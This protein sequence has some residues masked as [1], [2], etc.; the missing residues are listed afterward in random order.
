MRLPTLAMFS[1]ILVL[2]ALMY[3]ILYFGEL[4]ESTNYMQVSQDFSWE[5]FTWKLI[6]LL[7]FYHWFIQLT[8]SLPIYHGFAYRR[9]TILFTWIKRGLCWG[10]FGIGLIAS[11]THA[12]LCS[13]AVFWARIRS[14]LQ[15]NSRNCWWNTV[16]SKKEKGQAD[17]LPRLSAYCYP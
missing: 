15:E 12:Q 6:V 3:C 16:I 7:G 9:E 14:V 2:Q 4:E 17:L 11:G 5:Y 10:Y 1:A 8:Q 13:P